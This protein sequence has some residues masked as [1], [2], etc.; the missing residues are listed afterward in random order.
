MKEQVKTLIVCP[1]Y[2]PKIVC[3][4][5]NETFKLFLQNYGIDGEVIDHIPNVEEAHHKTI[6]IQSD[7][8]VPYEVLAAAKKI[9]VCYLSSGVIFPMRMM[10]SK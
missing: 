7:Q 6:V 10:L 3:W 4:C 9:L 8:I 2:G 5:D 1:E